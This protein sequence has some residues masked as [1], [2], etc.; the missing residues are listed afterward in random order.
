GG[1]LRG[2]VVIGEVRATGE[3]PPQRG[4]VVHHGFGP[5]LQ[6]VVAERVAVAVQRGGTP[7]HAHFQR[8]GH[9]PAGARRRGR[10]R[11]ARLPLHEPGPRHP[12]PTWGLGAAAV[13][14][15]RRGVVVGEVQ[16]A[17][18][19]RYARE[20]QLRGGAPPHRLQRREDQPV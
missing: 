16:H 11:R 18:A 8:E 15:L 5:A 2:E 19:H 4:E 1:D 17:V 13:A 10:R 14:T 9:L 7:V 12:L 20:R 3:R 6:L